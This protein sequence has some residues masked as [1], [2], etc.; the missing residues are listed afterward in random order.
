MKQLDVMARANDG[1]PTRL[2]W[3]ET[4][5]YQASRYLYRQYDAKTI[6]VEQARKEKDIIT[7]QYE[8]NKLEYEFLIRLHNV[9]DMLKRLNDQGFNTA[10]EQEILEEISRVLQ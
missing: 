4:V 9:E 1:M 8:E 10:I 5:Y 7:K 3:Y 6:T 2:M